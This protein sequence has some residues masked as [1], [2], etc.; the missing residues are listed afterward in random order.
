MKE[1]KCG[2]TTLLQTWISYRW[3][4]LRITNNEE[5]CDSIVEE[6][7]PRDL[8]IVGQDE[9]HEKVVLLQEVWCHY[10]R[11][12]ENYPKTPRILGAPQRSRASWVTRRGSSDEGEHLQTADKESVSSIND[13]KARKRELKS[14]RVADFQG[15]LHDERDG[16]I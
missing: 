7:L 11:V 6:P 8:G 12:I 10:R 13:I 1:L 14:L 4:L 15:L 3:R 16:H 5:Y 2:M 9:H